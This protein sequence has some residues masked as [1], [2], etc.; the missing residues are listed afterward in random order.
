MGTAAVQ[1]NRYE[2]PKPRAKL[3]LISV[4]AAAVTMGTMVILPG[5]LEF[6]DADGGTLARSQ[7]TVPIE[8]TVVGEDCAD[9][10]IPELRYP[11]PG[12]HARVTDALSMEQ[13]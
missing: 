10:P 9:W 1:S 12:L 4:A 6:A 3:A 8:V 2:S 13:P 7:T 5:W 11:P